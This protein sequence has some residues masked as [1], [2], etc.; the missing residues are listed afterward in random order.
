MLLG[1]FVSWLFQGFLVGVRGGG[2]VEKLVFA[3]G[4]MLVASG[5]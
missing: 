1:T 5:N 2:W 4:I 3:V